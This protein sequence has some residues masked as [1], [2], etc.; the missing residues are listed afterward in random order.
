VGG[1]ADSLRIDV[2]GLAERTFVVAL[3]GDLDLASA[4][5]LA[6]RLESLASDRALHVVVDLTG[7]EFVDS[8]GIHVL[9]AAARSLAAGAGRLTLVAP[10]SHTRRVLEIAHVPDLVAVADSAKAA[11]APPGGAEAG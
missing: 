3:A 1:P 4:P 2:A 11:L 5:D 9:L 6:R 10:P 8:S 7:L